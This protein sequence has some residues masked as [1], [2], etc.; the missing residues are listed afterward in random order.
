[1]TSTNP[2]GTNNQRPSTNPF[3]T[4]VG[5][6]TSGG[7]GNPFGGYVFS[8][9]DNA[10]N[11]AG[12]KNGSNPFGATSPATHKNSSGTRN[13]LALGR[14][15]FADKRNKAARAKNE[16]TRRTIYTPLD[17]GNAASAVSIQE[18]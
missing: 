5:K 7:A 9:N 14:K 13:K 16:S 2:F 1:M 12:N 11:R 15:K 18:G 17:R 4:A 10:S 3:D 8:D 6:S